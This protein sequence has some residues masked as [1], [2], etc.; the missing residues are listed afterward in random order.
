[1]KLTKTSVEALEVTGKR[2]SVHDDDLKGFTVRVGASGDK[3]FYYV[4]RAGKGRGTPIKWLRLG[5]F[6]TITVEQARRACKEKAG[7]VALGAD[8]AQVIQDWK[9]APTLK[10]SMDDF[11]ASHVEAKLKPSTKKG[12]EGMINRDINPALGKLK[13][14]DVQHR[15]VARLHHDMKVTPYLANRVLAVLSKFFSWAEKQGYRDRGSN[16]C[17]GIEKYREEKRR[18]FMGEDELSRLGNALTELEAAWH[19]R[20]AMRARKEPVP[21]DMSVV[22]PLKANAIRLLALTGARC[23]EILSLKWEYLDLDQGVAYLSDSKTGPKVL[24]L[25]AAAVEL[26]ES[27][28]PIT[29]WVF[30]GIGAH[31]VDVA[32]AWRA[33]CEKAGLTGWR[34]HDLRHAFAS[35]AVN[36]GHSLPQ[37]GALLGHSQP[38]TT[39]RYA[40][41]AENPVHKVS[42]DVGAKVAAAMAK[43]RSGAKVIKISGE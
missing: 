41:V 40:H 13:V 25:P 16:P 18:Q 34:L 32:K 4:Y 31:I 38:G 19:E 23:G 21:E 39:A 30:P 28:D 24:H 10:E 5:L 7:Q 36:S 1:M 29:E 20:E 37:V 43:T 27:L 11:L 17:V 9:K 42:E 33:A 2:Y 22:S 35:M 12:Y 15:H 3:T 6:P 26:L 14:A 8:P